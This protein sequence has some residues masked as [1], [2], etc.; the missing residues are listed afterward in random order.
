MVLNFNTVFSMKSL[1]L[2][3]MRLAWS[4]A[5]AVV[6]HVALLWALTP[7][8]VLA[9][10]RPARP[11]E[12]TWVEVPAVA[13]GPEATAAQPLPAPPSRQARRGH[14]R[15]EVAA[16]KPAEPPAPLAPAAPE[17]VVPT[18]A[19]EEGLAVGSLAPA[20]AEQ[21]EAEPG[22]PGA[23]QGTPAGDSLL[24][25]GPQDNGEWLA[26]YQSTVF[27]RVVASRRYPAQARRL[28]LVGTTTVRFC[29]RRDGHL[30]CPPT[31]QS[32]SHPMLDAAAL[33]IVQAA[34]PFPPLPSVASRE[35]VHFNVDIRF[36]LD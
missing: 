36:A 26:G 10:R 2:S 31:V 32:P 29:V 14:A 18:A 13:A 17:A 6:L 25:G 15:R 28:G 9:E 5:V 35:V 21:G 22:E 3:A 1:D 24:A 12:L 33:R 27:R 34:A 16:P 23:S 19:V 30:A 7:G 11:V 20:A 4:S 8:E